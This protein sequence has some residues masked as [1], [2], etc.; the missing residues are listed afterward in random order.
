MIIQH[1]SHDIY[2]IRNHGNYIDTQTPVS[3]NYH[4]SVKLS[5]KKYVGLFTKKGKIY[6]WPTPDPHY[7]NT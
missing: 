1:Q 6:N 4:I 3:W 2:I 5:P 7:T